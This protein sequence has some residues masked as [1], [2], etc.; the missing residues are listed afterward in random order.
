MG[1]WIG[2][3]RI[4][5]LPFVVDIVLL[6][7]SI[8]DLQPSLERFAAECEVVGM[9]ISTS[10]SVRKDLNALFR[11]GMRCY[12]KVRSLSILVSCSQVRKE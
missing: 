12:L 3:V 2:D 10:N 1:V 8:C 11:F 5:F 4:A 6:A 9:R 7:S